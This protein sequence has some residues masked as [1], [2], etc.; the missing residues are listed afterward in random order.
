MRTRLVAFIEPIEA[1]RDA[2]IAVGVAR[3]KIVRLRPDTELILALNATVEGQTTAH[4]IADRAA[5]VASEGATVWVQ[6]YQLQ[7]VPRMLRDLRPDLVIGYF[8]HIPWPAPEVL[9]MLPGMH[10]AGEVGGDLRAARTGHAVVGRCHASSKRPGSGR[11]DAPDYVLCHTEKEGGTRIRPDGSSTATPIGD[12]SMAAQN[13]L[14]QVAVRR[15]DGTF[16][17][18]DDNS[19]VLINNQK[20]PIGTR[21]FGPVP[22]ELRAKN[23][24]KIISLAPEVL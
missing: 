7:L 17:K 6:D 11:D 13:R 3:E 20:E 21:I 1:R 8:H 15:P 5:Q 19:A 22:R 12:S 2:A 18:F 9:G 23:Q 14:R 10:G 24:M 16:L 4:Y